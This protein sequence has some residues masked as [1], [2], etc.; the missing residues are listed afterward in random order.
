M[1]VRDTN[2][3]YL[4]LRKRFWKQSLTS[5]LETGF[6]IIKNKMEKEIWKDVVGY[7]SFYVISNQGRVKSLSR[8]VKR[9]R[10][11]P[12]CILK[13]A[14]SSKGYN[15]IGLSKNSI[16][17]TF[18]VSRL[19]AIHFIPN[20][21]NKSAVNHID[22]NKSN[23]FANNLEWVT[24]K[25][26]NAHAVKIGLMNHPFGEQCRNS[27]LNDKSILQ[28][29]KMFIETEPNQTK[30]AKIFNVDQSTINSIIK[31]KTWRHI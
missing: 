23:N 22:G 7:E 13:G 6:F 11:V 3:I 28:I 24:T 15:L 4:V 31:R 18:R 12:E 5:I 26:N 8:K 29:R 20:P 19:V 1:L 10:P 14:L 16:P 21:E 2:N 17:K 30:I 27:K 25:E 9:S